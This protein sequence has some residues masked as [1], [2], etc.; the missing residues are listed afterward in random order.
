MTG[1]GSVYKLCDT[2]TTQTFNLTKGTEHSTELQKW[3]LL[4]NCQY[5]IGMHDIT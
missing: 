4:Q 3:Y 2:V 5:V 1:V